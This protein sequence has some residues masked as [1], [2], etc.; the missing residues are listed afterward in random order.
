MGALTL[1]LQV[2]TKRGKKEKKFNFYSFNLAFHSVSFPFSLRSFLH[3][4]LFLH[5]Q[6]FNG[7]LWE[8]T[9]RTSH[10]RKQRC[11]RLVFEARLCPPLSQHLFFFWAACSFTFLLQA[12]F[13]SSSLFRFT[14][15]GF[16]KPH[17]TVKKRF[18]TNRR[19][20]AHINPYTQHKATLR[21]P[22]HQ[23]G[24]GVSELST[25]NTLTV[26]FS[27]FFFT[28]GTLR[29]YRFFPK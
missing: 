13:S 20:K 22:F 23:W 6:L 8:S 25:G 16:F 2:L 14:S 17:S 4:L 27:F 3:T 18:L 5:K 12:V 26:V 7:L 29:R 9:Y 1:W 28:S 24:S 10:L 11:Q 15:F 21:A 19:A